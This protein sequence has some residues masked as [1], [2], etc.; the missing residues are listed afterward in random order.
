[1]QMVFGKFTTQALSV[2]ARFRIADHLATGPKTAS[3]LAAA[4]GLNSGHLYRLMRALTGLR[5][6]EADESGR[7]SLTPMGNMLRSDVSGSVRAIATYVAD[8]WSWKPWG[9]LA[10][11]IKSGQPV[12]NRMFGEGAFDYL[13]KHPDEAR[14]FNE[15]MTGFSQ[16]A[17]AAVMKVYDFSKFG[18]IVDVGGGYGTLLIAILNETQSARGI[19]FDAPSVAAEAAKAISAAGLSER[20][21]AEG[22]DFF[23]A[24]PAH[25]DLYLLKHVIH[26]WNDASATRI[27][28]TCRSAIPPS[29]K[30]LLVETIVPPGF[31]PH[32]SH[33]L[34]LEMMVLCDGKERTEPEYREVLAGSGFR[35]TR[36]IPTEGAH[37][38]IEAVPV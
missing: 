7:F 38:L 26:D 10:E 36:V 8:P 16:Q 34:D 1:M 11:C 2:V 30:L 35:L 14:T 20:C 28:R 12:F 23:E 33:M 22:G 18:T 19:V 13:G 31:A 9:E 6:F 24:V 25:G 29:G 15:G 5:L 4:I 17:A 21:R 3:E 37:G 32:M 27:L